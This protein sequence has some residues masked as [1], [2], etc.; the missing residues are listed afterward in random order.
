VY[1]VEAALL[2]TFKFSL[3]FLTAAAPVKI[4]TTINPIAIKLRGSTNPPTKDLIFVGI[5]INL[6]YFLLGFNG[7]LE[8]E[9]LTQNF[10]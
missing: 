6:V 2:L 3:L 5:K 8:K 9:P 1:T 4:L 10:I 7:E